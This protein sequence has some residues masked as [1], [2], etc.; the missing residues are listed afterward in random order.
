MISPARVSIPASRA[1][2]NGQ[3]LILI[4]MYMEAITTIRIL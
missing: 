3:T 2:L 1:H 4:F